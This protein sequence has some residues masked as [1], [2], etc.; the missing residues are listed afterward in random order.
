MLLAAAI[1]RSQYANRNSKDMINEDV[2]EEWRFLW[3]VQTW[4]TGCG[5]P[6]LRFPVSLDYSECFK[7]KFGLLQ[8]I[9]KTSGI[10]LPTLPTKT[11]TWR[12]LMSDDLEETGALLLFAV[13]VFW[14]TSLVDRPVTI[15]LGR[16]EYVTPWATR[17]RLIGKGPAG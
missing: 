10:H 1:S 3:W 17:I 16:P 4:I 7:E 8:C 13:D 5:L 12:F 15:T 6:R 14:L 2:C 9:F 11:K